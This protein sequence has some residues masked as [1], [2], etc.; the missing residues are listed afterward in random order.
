MSNA[1]FDI[2]REDPGSSFFKMIASYTSDS[3]LRGLGTS[4]TGQN[5]SFKDE[6]VMSGESYRYKIQ[7]V[8]G[9]GTIKD[10]STLS[11]TVDVPKSYAL[12]QNYP[13]PFNPSTM[14]RFDLERQSAVTLYIYN[15]LGEKVEERNYGI[16]DAGRYNET[17]NMDR[18][19]SGV[20]Y[21]RINAVGNDGQR[22]VSVKKLVLMK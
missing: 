17:L 13:N 7:S 9:N 1:G 2:L 19:A 20:Y 6:H 18:F 10:L 16:M 5:Y 12:Y 22:F 4:T 21:C 8:S 15:V 3:G 11:V 14:I